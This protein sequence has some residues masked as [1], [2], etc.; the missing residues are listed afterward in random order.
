MVDPIEQFFQRLAREDKE[1]DRYVVPPVV[2]RKAKV[3]PFIKYTIRDD[4]KPDYA[5]QIEYTGLLDNTKYMIIV[6]NSDK[7]IK[8]NKDLQRMW[9]SFWGEIDQRY[10][11]I[12]NLEKLKCIDN[13][14]GLDVE[15]WKNLNIPEELRYDH[16]KGYPAFCE[17]YKVFRTRAEQGTK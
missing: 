15:A 1:V 6:I 2:K 11:V 9:P 10:V 7:Y 5:V 3:K 13:A 14:R 16:P 17:A 8:E 4:Y 12:I